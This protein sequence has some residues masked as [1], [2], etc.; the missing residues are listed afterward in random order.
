MVEPAKR[1]V[2]YA[3]YVA[4]QSSSEVRLE[5]LGG[6]VVAMARGTVAHGRL[7]SRLTVLLSSEL[8]GRRC[9]VLP[10]DVRVRIRAADR[11]TYPDLHVV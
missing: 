5:Y 9:A 2:N 8:E 1:R 6:L 7:I 3:E 4:M 10:T 11:A